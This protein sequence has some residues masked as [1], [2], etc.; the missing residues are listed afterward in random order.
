MVH[1]ILSWSICTS[2][3]AGTCWYSSVVLVECPPICRVYGQMNTQTPWN[4]DYH[5]DINV[6]MN[7]W[8]AEVTNLADCHQPLFTLLGQ[9]ADYGSHTAKTY[10]GARGWVTHPITNPW[11]YFAGR[12]FQLG[13]N[14]NGWYM[15]C[16]AFCGNITSIILIKNFLHPYIQSLKALHNSTRIF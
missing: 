1:Q 11:G 7:Y 2:A 10:Y 8:P 12:K 14:C 4:G 16:Y 13:L 9:M 15:G 3:L 6:Q 5:T